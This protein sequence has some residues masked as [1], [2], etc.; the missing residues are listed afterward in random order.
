MYCTFCV[1]LYSMYYI[2]NILVTQIFICFQVSLF[3]WQGK[4]IYMIIYMYVHSTFHLCKVNEIDMSQQIRL[5]RV[6]PRLDPGTGHPGTSCH[7][8]HKSHQCPYC[9]YNTK[10][11][12]RL[13]SHMRTHTGEKPFT[14]S[15]CAASFAT[16]ARLKTHIFT[17]T[18]EKPFACPYCSHR[19]SRKDS[20]KTHILTFHS[21]LPY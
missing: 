20:L 16:K 13:R 14:C 6:D 15:Y 12:S 3:L 17:H 7:V 10:F 19:T 8:G 2:H 1:C 21:A 9:T 4:N 5:V 18:G 11:T